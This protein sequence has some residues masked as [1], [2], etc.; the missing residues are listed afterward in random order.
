M[1]MVSPILQAS[2]APCR[3]GKRGRRHLRQIGA[4][5]TQQLGSLAGTAVWLDRQ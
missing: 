3:A 5:R 2:M 1:A 4:D